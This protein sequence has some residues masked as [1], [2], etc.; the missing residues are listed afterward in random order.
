MTGH[1]GQTGWPFPT[2]STISRKTKA[3]FR[4]ALA[5]I[6][7]SLPAIVSTAGGKLMESPPMQPPLHSSCFVMAAAAM[8]HAFIS[9]NKTYNNWPTTS[10]LKLASLIIRPILHP[11]YTSKYNPIE[12]RLFAHLSRVCQGVVFESVERVQDLMATAS[13]QT[14][15]E[16]FTSIIDAVYETGRRATDAFIENTPI[17]FDDRLPN[18]N[19]AA[20]PQTT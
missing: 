14:G 9:S 4:L 6:R 19:Y 7:Q 17:V 3:T 12:H 10:T 2:A 8:A 11:P 1:L 20:Q 18:W 13:T 16:V 5:A 15:L